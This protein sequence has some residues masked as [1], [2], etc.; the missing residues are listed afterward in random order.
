[1]IIKLPMLN[2]HKIASAAEPFGPCSHWTNHCRALLT[3]FVRRFTSLPNGMS[4]LCVCTVLNKILP[5][6]SVDYFWSILNF[7]ALLYIHCM[8]R[9]LIQFPVFSF[10]CNTYCL[11][12]I[13]FDVFFISSWFI[14]ISLC[15]FP[16]SSIRPSR[17]CLIPISTHV[18]PFIKLQ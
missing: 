4:G 16:L 9:R 12:H 13:A 6:F 2:D 10:Y 7:P 3:S 11:M 18:S 1:M 8:A 15:H 17:T 14:L 5:P